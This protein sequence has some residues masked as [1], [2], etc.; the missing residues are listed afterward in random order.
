MTAETTIR[1]RAARLR[2]LEAE[3]ARLVEDLQAAQAAGVP[4]AQL[5]EWTGLSRRT[6]FYM[7]KRAA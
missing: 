5:V 3:R 7:L 4:A 2:E 6:V 1:K